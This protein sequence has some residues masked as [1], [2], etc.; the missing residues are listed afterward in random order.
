MLF[1]S[2]NGFLVLLYSQ[3]VKLNINLYFDLFLNNVGSLEH[4]NSIEFPLNKCSYCQTFYEYTMGILNFADI[5]A[6]LCSHWILPYIYCPP[7][8]FPLHFSFCLR[9]F[10]F[11]SKNTVKSLPS[12]LR[13]IFAG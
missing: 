5:V 10:F 4:V 8:P 3:F 9:S 11:C 2:F 6:V 1:I 13:D 12:F 7:P